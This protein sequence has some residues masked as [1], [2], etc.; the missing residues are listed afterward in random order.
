MLGFGGWL[1]MSLY[2]AALI[3]AV[4]NS[5]WWIGV[6]VLWGNFLL[7]SMLET[8]DAQGK[9]NFEAFNAARAA[10]G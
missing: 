5:S 1:G 9:E 3:F 4:A 7:E 6:P 8:L 2:L 10:T